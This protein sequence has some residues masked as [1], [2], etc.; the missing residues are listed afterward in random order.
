MLEVTLPSAPLIEPR[1]E[2]SAMKMPIA[3]TA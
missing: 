2:P 1:T 3:M